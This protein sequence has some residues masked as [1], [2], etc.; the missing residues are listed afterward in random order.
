MISNIL[1]AAFLLASPAQAAVRAV[2][3][4][5]EMAWLL[6][7]VGG[8]K[9]EVKALGKPGDN[10][11]FL[12][13]RPDFILA[14][15]RADILCRVGAELEIG[16]LPK[17]LDRAANTKVMSGGAGDCDASR[18]VSLEEKPTKAVDRSMGDVHAAGNPHFWLSP[19]ETAKAAREVEEKLAAV[20]P[21]NARAFATNRE[22]LEK[23]LSGL[24]EKL[25]AKVKKG[26]SA[27]QYHKDFSYFFSAY[28]INSLG[29]IEEIP[30]VSPSAARLGKVAL[31]AKEKKAAFAL[32]AEHDPASAL[33]KFQELSGVKVVKL[34]TS[35]SDFR[36]PAAY[37]KWQ[38]AL[39]GTLFP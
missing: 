35:L 29:S 8:D 25:R 24:Q 23:E 26:V 38:E 39:V 36:D 27:Y 14:A 17:I 20:S 37:A 34:P 16:W 10:Y 9:V 32:A 7:R 13:A 19:A 31:E 15:N 3:T 6:Q 30:G 18:A 22:A 28:G 1:L 33:A 4:T 5:P 2:G 21:E 12:D 11:H